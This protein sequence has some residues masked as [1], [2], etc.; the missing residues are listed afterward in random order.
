MTRD[1]S[2]LPNIVATNICKPRSPVDLAPDCSSYNLRV[3]G[4]DHPIQ[5]PMASRDLLEIRDMMVKQ[6]KPKGMRA[7]RRMVRGFSKQVFG[8]LVS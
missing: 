8:V 1:L 3:Q 5:L 6:K 4:L 2:L 7:G